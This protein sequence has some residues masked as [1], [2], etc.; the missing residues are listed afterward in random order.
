MAAPGGKYF[1]QEKLQNP[2]PH[3][4]S[5]KQLWE[6]KWKLPVGTPMANR[7]GIAHLTLSTSAKWASILSCSGR[8]KILSLL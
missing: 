3:H 8:L 7:A 5:Y 1:I 6:T 4:T 2:A